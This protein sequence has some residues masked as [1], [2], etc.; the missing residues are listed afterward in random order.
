MQLR[1]NIRTI[2]CIGLGL[3]TVSPSFA[4]SS[5]GTSTAKASR[6]N[7]S[8]KSGGNFGLG[9]MLGDPSGL[10]AKLWT[11]H[12]TAFALGLSYSFGDYFAILGDHLWHFPNALAGAGSPAN[13][14]VPY[15]G[16]G[17]VLFFDDDGNFRDRNDR[18]VALGARIP[19]GIEFLPRTIPLGVFAEVVPGVGIVPDVFGFVQ[20]DIGAR[21][22][23]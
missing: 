5:L 22:Y 17:A 10:T 14:F 21:F 16:L 15:I 1:V 2:L 8:S 9:V 6:P 12:S 13:Q 23:F 18:D 20:G 7:S 11:S 3:L 19:L 4:A